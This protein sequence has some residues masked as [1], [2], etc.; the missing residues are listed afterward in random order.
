MNKKIRVVIYAR[1]STD[2]QRDASIEDQVA[3][4]RD[5]AIRQGWEIVQTY[6]DLP[7][8]SSLAVM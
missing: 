2:K 6:S 8:G 5:F 4:C 3:S 7:P 1:F